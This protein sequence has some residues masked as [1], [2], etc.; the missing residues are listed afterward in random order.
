MLQ[1]F[2]DQPW[3]IVACDALA[4]VRGLAATAALLWAA[5]V[6]R[7]PAQR[8]DPGWNLLAAGAIAWTLADIIW[9]WLAIA[10]A[11]PWGS[12]ADIFFLLVY[13]LF[14]GGVLLLPRQRHRGGGRTAAVLDLFAILVAAGAWTWQIAMAPN[15]AAGGAIDLST[16]VTLAYPVGD[17][18]LLWAALDLLL[19]GRLDAPRGVAG[20]LAAGAAVLIATDLVYAVQVAHGSYANGNALGIAWALA[21]VLVALA[22]VRRACAGA[23]V[24]RAPDP[25]PMASPLLAAIALAATWALLVTRPGETVPAAAAGVA[26]ALLLLRQYAVMRANQR[27]ERSL[28]EANAGLEQRVRERTAELADT[29]RR[30]HEAER[31]EAVGRVAAAVAHD[32]NNVLAA[33]AGHAELA[34]LRSPPEAAAHLDGILD[35]TSRAGEVA[36]RLIATARPHPVALASVDVVGLVREV[37]AAVQPMLPPGI[38]LTCSLPEGPLAVP[39][40]PG[41]L[42]Q[43]LLNLVLNARDAMPDGGELRIS[44]AASEGWVRLEVSDTGIGM[45]ARVQ[46]RLFEP[47]FTTKPKG[48]GNGLGLASVHAIVRRHGGTVSV[49]SAPG[50]GSTFM[51]AL[52]TGAPRH[53]S[54]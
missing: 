30:L 19:R 43:V 4:I 7:G 12:L 26:L 39:A 49:A 42:H 53:G 16:V 9:L 23:A 8:L 51:V 1:V 47:C 15:L 45:D 38:R 50:S 22:G 44:T 14:L 54:R 24:P 32:F 52:P 2:G 6:A 25:P 31:H 36:R 28:A 13:P 29:Q 34:R 17:V 11:Q 27:L 5:R 21:I 3:R 46:A 40:D 10:G 18:L 33:V 41:Q 35:A 48:I 20:L 37:A